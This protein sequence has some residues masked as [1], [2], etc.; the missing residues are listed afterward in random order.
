MSTP[1]VRHTGRSGVRG[2]SARPARPALLPA[3]NPLT[4]ALR[5]AGRGSEQGAAALFLPAQTPFKTILTI[6]NLNPSPHPRCAGR[7]SEQ[8]AQARARRDRQRAG[9]EAGSRRAALR[10]RHPRRPDDRHRQVGEGWASGMEGRVGRLSGA[11]QRWR[12]QCRMRLG[13]AQSEWGTSMRPWGWEIASA[14]QPRWRRAIPRPQPYR[15]CTRPLTHA[16]AP[17]CMHTHAHAQP[18]C[19]PAG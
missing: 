18:S 14:A 12:L 7:G 1:A 2:Q 17:S 10:R 19:L 15:A 5:C 13:P 8:G 9:Q 6:P 4:S 3:C 16:H 11:G